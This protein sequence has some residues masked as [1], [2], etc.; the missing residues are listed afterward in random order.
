MIS[1][2]RINHSQE[3][4][5]TH[6]TIPECWT[7]HEVSAHTNDRAGNGEDKRA[8]PPYLKLS[9]ALKQK[10][11]KEEK[12]ELDAENA[13]IKKNVG[14]VLKLDVKVKLVSE[15]GWRSFHA[16]T[17]IDFCLIVG[18]YEKYRDSASH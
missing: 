16:S 13:T 5:R 14:K 9:R 18:Q 2:A 15:I 11:K 17:H 6:D 12:G 4:P 8:P 3:K 7:G 10:S 1:Q